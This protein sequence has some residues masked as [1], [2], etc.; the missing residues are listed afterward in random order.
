MGQVGSKLRPRWAMMAPRW[1]S[2]AQFGSFWGVLGVCQQVE[3]SYIDDVAFVP[4]RQNSLFIDR[5]T[6]IVSIVF[7]R[8]YLHLLKINFLPGKTEIAVALK[9]RNATKLL[10]PSGPWTIVS[11]LF[12]GCL[13]MFL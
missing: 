13:V 7:N 6:K 8:V 1:P 3:C 2:W 5:I 10:L 11:F 12:L 9:G 4:S